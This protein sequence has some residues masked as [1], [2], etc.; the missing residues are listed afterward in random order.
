MF[1]NLGPPGVTPPQAYFPTRTFTP[2]GSPSGT[3]IPYN[4][5]YLFLV[6]GR[7]DDGDGR[8]DEGWNGLDDDLRNGTDDNFEWEK[9]VW[10]G[11]IETTLQRLIFNPLTGA[12]DP[13]KIQNQHYTIVRRPI[14]SANARETTLPSGV[15]VDLTT[16]LLTQE[17]SR[18]PVG[19]INPYTGYVDIVLTPGG[20]VV[21][22]NIYSAP[23]S[24]G[25]TSAFYHFWL[26]ER[27]D[28]YQV[29][30]DNN[31]NA[32][33][34]VSGHPFLLPM[35]VGSNFSS[36]TNAYDLLVAANPGLP[37]LKGESRLV[38]LF[39]RTGQII[40]RDSPVFDVNNVSQPF[41]SPQQGVRGGQ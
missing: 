20:D 31:G 11:G 40:T 7:D 14:P 38:T 23:A 1:V 41:I 25:M 21:P 15:V 30:T 24:A 33:P 10:L 6:N 37:T 13:G 29:Q 2:P 34:L 26:A 9:E 16:A 28:L 4:P 5:E 12:F 27:G 32:V 18:F 36:P 22:T 35:P 19:T 17:R 8:I 39:T 3:L